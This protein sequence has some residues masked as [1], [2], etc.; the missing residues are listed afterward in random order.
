MT[1]GKTRMARGGD[2]NDPPFWVEYTIRR[3][4]FFFLV[5]L[6]ESAS[7]ESLFK[8]EKSCPLIDVIA[9]S[10]FTFICDMIL[11]YKLI[12]LLTSGECKSCFCTLILISISSTSARACQVRAA[13][14]HLLAVGSLYRA[15]LCSAAAGPYPVCFRAEP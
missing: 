7:E 8:I 10:H 1:R 9:K 4:A 11:N 3:T 12:F 6:S 13:N 14:R 15:A 2:R 5:I